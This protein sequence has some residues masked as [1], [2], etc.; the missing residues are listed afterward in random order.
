VTTALYRAIRDDEA[1]KLAGLPAEAHLPAA[2][3]LLDR[4]VERD[5]FLD[6]LTSPAYEQLD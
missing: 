2:K 4:L 3:A 6:F 1:A 5:D